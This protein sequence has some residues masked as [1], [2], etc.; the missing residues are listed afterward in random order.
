MVALY[1][2][3][4]MES[5]LRFFEH[6]PIPIYQHKCQLV[7]QH[8]HI[9]VLPITF[10]AFVVCV[11]G[12]PTL[13]NS[14]KFGRV[15]DRAQT[16]QPPFA[17]FRGFVSCGTTR[18]QIQD[19]STSKNVRLSYLYPTHLSNKEYQKMSIETQNPNPL[20]NI[21]LEVLLKQEWYRM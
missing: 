16:Q 7:S 8:S 21:L 2:E 6:E 3:K 18:Q 20:D 15:L 17:V 12:L 5:I 11:P 10:E 14:P 4:A 1:L 19:T 13:L 9:L